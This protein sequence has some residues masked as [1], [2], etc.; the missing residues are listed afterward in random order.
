MLTLLFLWSR[1]LEPQFILTREEKVEAGFSLRLVLIS[2]LHLGVY[3]DEAFLERLVQKMNETD[4]DMLLIAGDF[5]YYPELHQ[6]PA[7]FA[8]LQELQM[9]VYAVLGN[10]DVERPGP[11]LRNELRRVL[12]QYGVDL[13]ENE[14]VEFPNFTLIG[15]GDRWAGTHGEDDVSLLQSV[16]PEDYV[17]VLTH[18]P[19]TITDFPNDHADLTLTG[20]THGGQIRI[21]WLYHRVIPTEGGFDKGFFQT[22]ETLLYTTSGAGEVGLPMRLL[23]PP[24]I[25]IFDF[26]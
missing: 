14:I 23:S 25:V 19:D 12:E 1:F 18:N 24:E 8:P 26:H 17:I 11:K 20:H 2:D 4:A 7:L 13:L 6:L 15:M 3:K 16:V 22:E 5:T 10:H 9:P 21:P